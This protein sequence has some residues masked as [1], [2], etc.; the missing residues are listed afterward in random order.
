M[1]ELKFPAFIAYTS[2]TYPLLAF[3]IGVL[4]PHPITQFMKWVQ[5]SYREATK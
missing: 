3:P 2:L 4:T 5:L 1:P